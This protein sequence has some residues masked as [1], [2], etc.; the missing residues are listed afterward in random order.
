MEEERRKR[1]AE[2]DALT[3]TVPLVDALLEEVSKQAVKLPKAEILTDIVGPQATVSEA[4]NNDHNKQREGQLTQTSD[5]ANDAPANINVYI[6]STETRSSPE[7]Y[8]QALSP[9]SGT[10]RQNDYTAQNR[11]PPVS[12]QTGNTSNKDELGPR[13]AQIEDHHAAKEVKLTKQEDNTRSEPAIPSSAVPPAVGPV[14][15]KAEGP[16]VTPE[17]VYLIPELVHPQHVAPTSIHPEVGIFNTASPNITSPKDAVPKL[18]TPITTAP[19]DTTIETDR[20]ITAALYINSPQGV[21]QPQA[22]TPRTVARPEAE[23]SQAVNL[24]HSA[25]QEGQAT[26]TVG[27]V[28]NAQK[29]AALT[30]QAISG[31]VAKKRKRPAGKLAP[32]A[33]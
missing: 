3:E 14:A 27:H 11:A 28:N 16:L 22:K 32:P 18:M 9:L 4:I 8:L 7:E 15:A 24:N 25:Q 29:P 20:L 13:S 12:G 19:T 21:E 31:L 33:T 17:S 10:S 6:A 1:Q 26:V 23:L 2:N 30:A 5:Q